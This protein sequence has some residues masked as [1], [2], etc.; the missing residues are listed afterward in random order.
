MLSLRYA[1]Y[2]RCI[3]VQQKH[4]NLQTRRTSN[5]FRGRNRR[6]VLST[7]LTYATCY[8]YPKTEPITRR[9]TLR[10]ANGPGGTFNDE[11]TYRIQQVKSMASKLAC[12][13]F[14][15]S[16]VLMVYQVPCAIKQ[17]HSVYRSQHLRT[18]SATQFIAHSRYYKVMLPKLGINQHMKR[19][20]VIYGP[21]E[22]GRL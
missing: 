15:P 19:D 22:L 12:A 21:H 10:R 11:L 7:I 6:P 2:L 3:H 1:I 8:P 9:A 18:S 17:P 20:G 4:P 5:A 16:D 13:P 14:D